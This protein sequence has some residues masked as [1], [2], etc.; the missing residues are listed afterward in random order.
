LDTKGLTLKNEISNS[1]IY[2]KLGLKGRTNQHHENPK[3]LSLLSSLL[4]KHVETN[5]KL[6]Q[7][8][9]IKDV[10]TVFHGSRAPTLTI[11]QSIDRIYKYSRCSPSC[12]VGAHIYIDRLIQSQS[13]ILTSLNVHRL[14][15][16]SIMLAAKFIDD[17]FF[18]NTYY[19]KVGGITR[20]EM[21]RLE[22]KFLFGIDFQLYVSLST[23]EKYCLE[24]MSEGSRDKTHNKSRPTHT[25]HVARRITDNRSMNHDDHTIKIPIQ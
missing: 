17:A 18:N 13:I 15:I 23:F 21:N 10:P 22:L 14:L 8:T 16:T 20:A 3:V 6:L 12:F 11:Q 7:T 2:L 9:Q 5:E 19:A 24:L 1:K 4:Q 25:I